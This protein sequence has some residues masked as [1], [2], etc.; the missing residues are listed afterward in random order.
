MELLM[1]SSR[2]VEEIH[3]IIGNGNCLFRTLL[4]ALLNTEEHHLFIRSHIVRLINLNSSVF[5]QYLMPVNKPTISEQ[6]QHMSH[7]SVWGTHLE[8]KA[9]ATLF[10]LPIYFC[11]SSSTSVPFVWSVFQPI[12]PNNIKFPTI[13][14]EIL[15]DKQEI[16]HIQM[17]YHQSHYD[18][19]VSVE[20]DKVCEE[21]PHLTGRDDEQTITLN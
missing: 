5:S 20:N 2:S 12:Y 13:A 16:S 14:D 9:V 18:T 17:Y 21:P 7:P 3:S 4:Y 1:N 19:I 8:I 6:V 10:Q 15:K 11:M